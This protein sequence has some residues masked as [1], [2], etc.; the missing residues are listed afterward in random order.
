[1]LYTVK[2]IAALS[3]V[4]VKTLY[5][6][7]KIGLLVPCQVSEAG[8]RLYS[9]A[10]VERLQQI[11]FYRALDFSLK[12]IAEALSA[13]ADR[14]NVLARQRRLLAGRLERFQELIRTIDDTIGHIERDETMEN[15][16]LFKGFTAEE[17][18][19]ALK[20]QSAYLKENFGYELPGVNPE[21]VPAL[22]EMARE[23][24]RFQNRLA[25]L[26]REGVYC[27]DEKVGTMLQEHLDFLNNHRH[28]VDR[29]GFAAQV[30]FLVGD[31]FH[32]KMMETQQVG[33]AYY[34]LS[35]VES[36]VAAN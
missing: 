1:M 22:N 3:H 19:E 30:R 18:Q 7:H 27:A 11:L 16:D 10:E 25:E 35:A 24:A 21:E 8:Y 4:T 2:E 28:E 6:Y 29:K 26:L 20:E 15:E 12:D 33:L 32:R 14:R 13:D 23:A 9:Q 17:W 5:H 34:F 31:D 36:W